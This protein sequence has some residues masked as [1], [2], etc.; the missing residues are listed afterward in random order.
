M[1]KITGSKLKNK[2]SLAVS[3]IALCFSSLSQADTATGSSQANLLTQLSATS[4][5]SMNFGVI[6]PSGADQIVMRPEL[7]DAH[8]IS[9]TSGLSLLS[10]ESRVARFDLIGEPLSGIDIQADASVALSGPGTDMIVDDLYMINWTP[11]FHSTGIM[12]IRIGGTLNIN[13]SQAPGDY[14]GTFQ[15]TFSYQ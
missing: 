7:N 6:L 2:L 9:S 8:S 4:T 14:S 13:E 5:Q 15:V 1:K 10:G 3:S 11:S 12:Y